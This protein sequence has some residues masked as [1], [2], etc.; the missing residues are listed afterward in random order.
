MTDLLV[1]LGST[2]CGTLEMSTTGKL[3]FTYDDAYR[4]SSNAT[5]LSVSMPVDIGTFTDRTVAPWVAGLLPEDP[6]V[7]QRWRR[8][9]DLPSTDPF[10]IL[11][12]RVGEDCAG[13]VRF[14]PRDRLEESLGTRGSIEWLD[15]VQLEERLAE[16]R[17]DAAAWIDPSHRGQ[18]SLAGA[19]A[20]T[21][22]Y[23]EGDR[24]GVP[25]GSIPTTHIVKPGIAEFEH[26]EVN[27]YLCLAAARTAGLAA[28]RA[29]LLDV[30]RHAALV[31]ERYDRLRLDGVVARLHQEDLCQ[32]LGRF[33][34]D[35][36]Q[37]DGGPGPVDIVT[38]LRAV[39][40]GTRART[41]AVDA[42]LD[43]LAWNWIIG[44][45]DAH[46]KNWS[47]LLEG[48]DVRLAPLYD[49]ASGLPY[50]LHERKL[51]LAMKVGNDY[52][53]ALLSNPWPTMATMVGLDADQLVD[54]VR[55]LAR[56]APDAFSSRAKEA[57]VRRVARPFAAQL[58]DAIADRSRRIE[59]FLASR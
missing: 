9:F 56:R 55:T 17:R 36:Y 52:R 48:G 4:S 35:K 11:S 8:H 24:F 53:V 49:L 5:P 28:P 32:A 31:V 29:S 12:S 34:S 27:E 7:L 58:T 21:A 54:R 44:G 1:L 39:I 30:G 22:L 51:R 18:F 41:D 26:H 38:L 47:L 40:T 6:N 19:Q 15:D 16:L 33:P 59:V 23:L 57:P 25:S 43:G 50:G 10:A 2:T 46:A 37:A 13:A 20:K 14:V 42:F 45:T 3:R